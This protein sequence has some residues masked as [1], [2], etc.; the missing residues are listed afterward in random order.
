MFMKAFNSFQI[1]SLFAAGPFLIEWVKN[2][3]FYG[4]SALFWVLLV[5]YGIGF[6]AMCCAVFHA[7]TKSY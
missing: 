2:A 1:V 7:S 6:I 5:G 4:H 3:V